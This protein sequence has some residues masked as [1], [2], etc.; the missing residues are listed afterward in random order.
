VVFGFGVIKTFIDIMIV[1][2]PI[3]LVLRLQMSTSQKR[4][5]ILLLGLGYIVTA[6]GVIRTYYSYYIM[7]R[8]YDETW[9]EYYGF[10]ASTI[11]NDLA[12]VCACAPALRPVI[13]RLAF[14]LSPIPSYVMSSLRSSPKDSEFRSQKSKKSMAQSSGTIESDG[15]ISEPRPRR[16]PVTD[17]RGYTFWRTT[18]DD[19]SDEYSAEDLRGESS[20][21]GLRPRAHD[22]EGGFQ[23]E[24][25]NRAETPKFEKEEPL[26]IR[27]PREATFRTYRIDNNPYQGGNGHYFP[28][29]QIYH[30]R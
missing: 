7:W 19:E 17:F 3:P 25:L 9:Y 21:A 14:T 29:Q 12:I 16:P 20:Q 26:P 10:V 23:R 27:D 2:L 28:N 22:V 18:M 8:S 30:G 4:A 6:A 15:V 24:A 5:V 11:E 13:T 1:T